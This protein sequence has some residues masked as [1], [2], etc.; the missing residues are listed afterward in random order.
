MSIKNIPMANY[1]HSKTL[2]RAACLSEIRILKEEYIQKQL[3][4]YQLELDEALRVALEEF[5]ATNANLQVNNA[6]TADTVAPEEKA[7]AVSSVVESEASSN[8]STPV[9]TEE[10]FIEDFKKLNQEKFDAFNLE[11]KKKLEREMR[12]LS[13]ERLSVLYTLYS[14]EFDQERFKNS[15]V[16][17]SNILNDGDSLPTFWFIKDEA[18]S[19]SLEFF[20]NKLPVNQ[21]V[22]PT[23]IL[24]LLRLNYNMLS[25]LEKFRKVKFKKYRL[26]RRK[27]RKL[28]VLKKLKRTIVFR[29]VKKRTFR[30]RSFFDA[31]EM[32]SSVLER[33]I[34]ISR[35]PVSKRVI[36]NTSVE[37][38]YK[39]N[40]KKNRN[41]IEDFDIIDEERPDLFVYLRNYHQ[42]PYHKLRKAR[43]A[44][45]NLFFNKTLRKQRYKGFIDRFVKKPNK[46]T[47]ALS[48]FANVFTKLKFSWTR[49]DK[50]ESFFK[51]YI[52]EYSKNILRIPM[53]FTNFFRWKILKKRS[54]FLRKKMGRWSY[55][56]FRR[57]TCPW[58]QRK[59]NTPK[60]NYHIQPNMFYFHA[61]SYWDFMTGF[62]YL[63]EDVRQHSVP[64]YDQ[65]K[66]NLLVKLH[67]YRYK[68]NNKCISR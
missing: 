56:N 33:N 29:K 59:K 66:T 19:H 42:K 43:I 8:D 9:I 26:K 41:V 32:D 51:L 12:A 52:V 6:E 68:A 61:I 45:W 53:L 67:M 55:L 46:L 34:L 21:F 18:I 1:L 60:I 31:F 15:Y 3:D 35:M 17:F 7:E 22:D 50:L 62:L 2:L 4:S 36:E 37:F 65:F 11:L 63:E 5:R 25:V 30:T 64:P 44:H 54:F 24:F 13:L 23:V 20:L 47:Y 10:M 39:L 58:L 49:I 40:K 48:Y 28:Y 57:A 38:F 14:K 16:E 27:L